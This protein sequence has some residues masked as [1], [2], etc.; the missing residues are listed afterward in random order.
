MGRSAGANKTFVCPFVLRKVCKL[1]GN[2]AEVLPHGGKQGGYSLAAPLAQL[3]RVHPSQGLRYQLGDMRV[4]DE[5]GVH[6]APRVVAIAQ[7]V[8]EGAVQGCG[9]AV[10]VQEQHVGD[11]GR[12]IDE[13]L[14]LLAVDAQQHRILPQGAPA[15]PAA[16][17]L[18]C[19]S[20][21]KRLKADIVQVPIRSHMSKHL[22]RT[23]AER[24]LRRAINK[25]IH[26]PEVL[27]LL[28]SPVLQLKH[29]AAVCSV[30]C[31]SSA[32][33]VAC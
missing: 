22:Q 2:E 6:D 16:H 9:K 11:L 19:D 21:C 29:G 7:A 3:Q 14:R 23:A 25:H 20:V 15:F 17:Q 26:N 24:F 12:P 8:A 13:Q 10:R 4:A 5:G 33:A 18:V 28:P 1:C 30:P 27:V 31:A 32:H